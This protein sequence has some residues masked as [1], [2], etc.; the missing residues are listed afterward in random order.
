MA[1]QQRFRQA[2]LFGKTVM[3]DPETKALYA[4]VAGAKGKP[5]FSLTVADFFHAP[6]VGEVDLSAYT[7]AIGDEIIIMAGDDF[8]P[9]INSGQV[10]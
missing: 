2:V 7:G 3:A 8:D 5:V 4:E 10:S 9:S 1:V 6:S